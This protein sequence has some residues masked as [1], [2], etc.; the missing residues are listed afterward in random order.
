MTDPD[1]EH[2]AD[3]I[4]RRLLDAQREERNEENDHLRKEFEATDRIAESLAT[5]D[6]SRSDT[7]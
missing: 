5:R 1:A 6:P 3:Q 4:S 2:T 7:D